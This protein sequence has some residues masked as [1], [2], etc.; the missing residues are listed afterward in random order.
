L[1]NDVSRFPNEEFMMMLWIPY[2]L[3]FT[4]VVAFVW[5]T[6]QVGRLTEELNIVRRKLVEEGGVLDHTVNAIVE[7]FDGT[8]YYYRPVFYDR[9]AMEALAL[10]NL[11]QD[12]R[13]LSK[14]VG[15]GESAGWGHAFDVLA[16][17]RVRLIVGRVALSASASDQFKEGMDKL[18]DNLKRFEMLRGVRRANIRE[19]APYELSN[20]RWGHLQLAQLGAASTQEEARNLMKL[21]EQDQWKAV[22]Q[23]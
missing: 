4:A 17:Y 18:M 21:L 8:L 16:H 19:H 9:A 20:E 10:D 15:F 22:P 2:V 13:V 11:T 1:W 14:F 12:L 3:L 5:R 7:D 6:T 23:S